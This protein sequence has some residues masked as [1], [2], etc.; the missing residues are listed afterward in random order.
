M[1]L[2]TILD[3]VSPTPERPARS[4]CVPEMSNNARIII[5]ADSDHVPSALGHEGGG[6]GQRWRST[7]TFAFLREL[8]L[9]VRL[10]FLQ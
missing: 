5:T 4:A 7:I 6:P 3:A 10:V 8:R 9:A 2:T 1:M